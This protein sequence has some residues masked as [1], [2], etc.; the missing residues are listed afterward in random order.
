MSLRVELR[1]FYWVVGAILV[2]PLVAGLVGAF[3]GLEGM[4][5]LF[6]I[7]DPIVVP[8]SLRNNLRAICFMFFAWGPL[9]TW[10]LAALRERAGAFRITVGCGFVAGF[11]RLTGYLVDGYPGLFPVLIMTIELGVMPILFLWHARLVRLERA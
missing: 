6:N 5:R 8:P 7:K 11:A 1:A 9:V 10:S 4:A 3:G 2:I